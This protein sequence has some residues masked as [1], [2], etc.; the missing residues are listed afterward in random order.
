MN[1]SKFAVRR[2]VTIT[3]MM[4]V[5]ILLGTISL[6][7]LPLDLMP[8]IE[9]PVAIVSTTY[10]GV[11]PHEMENLVTRPIEDAVATVADLDTVTSMSSQGNS[12]V[13]ARFDFG[14]NMDFAALEMREKVDMVR[15]RLPDDASQPMVM[16]LDM[17][18]MPIVMLSLS[19]GEDLF[20]LQALAEDTMK[21]RL[22]RI[23]GVASVSIVG[24]YVNEIEI[25]VNQQKL[26][27]YGIGVDQLTQVVSASNIN[28][29]GGTVERGTEKLT[30]RT[31]GEFE[32]VE[33]IGELPI[34]LSSGSIIRLKDVAEVG[35]IQKEIESISRT[36]GKNGIGI[37]IQKQSGSNTVQVANSV[38]REVEKLRAD[39]PEFEIVTIFDQSDYINDAIANVAKNA[40]V[41]G[42]LAIL[43]LYLFLRNIRSTMII[44]TA[45]PISIIATF[46]LLYF[47]GITLNLMTLGGLALGVGM[48][49]DNAIVVLENIYRYRMEGYSRVEAAIEGAKEVSM[50]VT[51]S[52]LTTIAVFAPIVF[53]GGLTS[54][55][56]GE[57]AMTVTLSLVASLVVAL[58]FIPMLSSKILK[59]ERIEEG[60]KSKKRKIFTGIYDLFDRCFAGLEKSY[61]K[62][63][64][65]G[66]GHRKTLIFMTIVVFV[67]SVSSVFL[68]G[69][70]FFPASDQGQIDVSVTL[71]TGSQLSETDETLQRIEAAIAPI[72]EIDIV[73]TTIG[74]GMG[75]GFASSSDNRGS[76]TVM[77]VGLSQRNRSAD[78][79]A[80]EIRSLVRDIAGAE[81]SVS[82][83]DGMAMGGASAPIEIK[84]KGDDLETLEE[85]TEDFRRMIA[86]VE[87]T[88]DVKTSFSEGVPELQIHI[89]K[90]EAST[91]GLTTAQ[92]ANSVR[93]FALGTTVSRFREDGDETNII[94]RG[95]ENI[96]QDLANLEQIGI[97]TPMGS[98]V[99]LN[100]VADMYITQG[101]T[102]INR[103]D[104]H[105]V[106]TVTSELSG[107]DL[108][109]VTRDIT[110]LL[111]AYELPEGYFYQMGGENEQMVEAFA[112]LLLA[113]VLAIILVYMVMA[114]QFESLMH[115]FTIIMSIPLAFSGGFL[116]LFITGRT[117]NVPAF[118]GLLMLAGIVINNGIVLVDYINILRN[119]GKD[120]SEAITIAGPTRLRPILMTTLTTV[121]AMVP[122]ALG[123]GE[124]AEAQAPMA[125]TVVGGL[126]LSTV[127]T[128][129]VTP[130]IYT[131]MD[132]LAMTVKRKL[133]RK[134]RETTAN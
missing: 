85:I 120:R 1:L 70:E 7:R 66:L 56:F 51:A 92:V 133:K 62:M 112:D 106:A 124:G 53:V 39:Y 83:A 89:N 50:A 59:V 129:L 131:I 52:T 122:L 72:E 118:I 41:G 108:V 94:I 105:R 115:P 99:P 17:N 44:A 13:V 55:L 22:E 47:N 63:L 114:S 90:Y 20:A 29:P 78:E 37:Q 113:I 61:K 16:K 24:D 88:R 103:E 4:L 11:G 28:V 49:V 121:L 109:S 130:I 77:L 123:I 81:I 34:T 54:I 35:L 27:A 5:I 102:S 21:P 119:A 26:N 97:Q 46:V 95:E 23:S 15:G 31:L 18:A 64:I 98:T 79:V 19:N 40:L 14:T 86:Q 132:D 104:Q 69:A 91:Y 6:T 48:L 65:W 32:T 42:A 68:V 80:D 9:I 84:V 111:E 25:K 125:T 117:L 2:P 12:I 134:G 38:N 82:S 33:E 30:I 127:L 96:R 126:L 76:M 101:P 3:M 45:L 128:L 67:G 107:R 73:Y 36:N 57:F 110:A 74:G 93:S 100:Q 10:S 8:D 116:G 43:I 71:P 58:T 87:G 60:E 75:A